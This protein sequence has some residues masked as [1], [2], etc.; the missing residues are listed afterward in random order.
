MSE[1]RE[2]YES[3]RSGDGPFHSFTPQ[4]P[5]AQAG[6][7][8]KPSEG[9]RGGAAMKASARLDGSTLW[10]DEPQ[11]GIDGRSHLWFRRQH[12]LVAGARP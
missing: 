12:E 5:E 3:R 11:E 10:K 6:L 9:E 2:S 7:N 1:G 8:V 4:Y